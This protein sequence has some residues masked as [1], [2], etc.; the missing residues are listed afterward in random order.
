VAIKTSDF[1]PHI[2]KSKAIPAIA[3]LAWN[4]GQYELAAYPNTKD[5]YSSLAHRNGPLTIALNH[6]LHPLQLTPGATWGDV[7]RKT[8]SKPGSPTWSWIM[9]DPTLLLPPKT[10]PQFQ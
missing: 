10:V 2:W 4:S 6:P 3:Y 9:G 1:Y 5:V 8:F 7:W